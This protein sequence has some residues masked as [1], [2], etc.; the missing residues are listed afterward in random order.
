MAVGEEEG[1]SFALSIDLLLLSDQVP[2]LILER[3]EK[4][5]LVDGGRGIAAS[6]TAQVWRASPVPCPPPRDRTLSKADRYSVTVVSLIECKTTVR[7]PPKLQVVMFSTGTKR[8]TI[9]FRLNLDQAIT[10]VM[11][12]LKIKGNNIALSNIFLWLSLTKQHWADMNTKHNNYSW[13]NI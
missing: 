10:G 2:Q 4:E 5:G 13:A 11:C 1:E 12:K 3:K 7:I 6:P 9:K 8:S